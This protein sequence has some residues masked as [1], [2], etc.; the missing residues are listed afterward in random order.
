[1]E[2]ECKVGLVSLPAELMA[3]IAAMLPIQSVNPFASCCKS[4]YARLEC[5]ATW[6][7]LVQEHFGQDAIHHG[8][9]D[10]SISSPVH[11][12]PT[13]NILPSRWSVY[14]R[15]YILLRA[16]S[17]S[18][19][20]YT[21]EISLHPKAPEFALFSTLLIGSYG[22][23]K[24]SMLARLMDNE[25]FA[26]RIWNGPIPEFRIARFKPDPSD[27]R[28]FRYWE[29]IGDRQAKMMV[30]L[31]LDCEFHFDVHNQTFIISIQIW[32]PSFPSLSDWR[33]YFRLPR[34][35]SESCS[36]SRW[37]TGIHLLSWKKLSSS[38][39]RTML[40]GEGSWTLF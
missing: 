4:I 35:A 23:G 13:I 33:R 7:Y 30:R 9:S 38:I 15:M 8:A 17:S 21:G 18:F 25:Y 6:M 19:M 16:K 12:I 40:R 24:R 34:L 10:G 2:A 39:S 27:V 26:G 20:K 28:L 14:K 3:I 31:C 36:A 37:T 1:M 5:D 11:D 22:C 29:D 32:Y